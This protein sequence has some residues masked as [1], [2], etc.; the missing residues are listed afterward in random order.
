MADEKKKEKK[1]KSSNV[2]W[3][4]ALV[5]EII[6]MGGLAFLFFIY[7]KNSKFDQIQTV[8]IE[9]KDLE[10]N[11]G[12][13]EQ[14]KGYT[15][16]AFFGIDSRENDSMLEGNRSD[17]IIIA[18][19]NNDTKEVKL[20]SVYRDTLLFVAANGGVTTKTTHAYA[21]GGPT[22]ALS[23][24]NHNLDLEVTDFITVNFLAL[25]K[26]IDDLGGIVIDVR[27]EE[28]P[29]L[30]TCITEQI[31]ITGVYSDGVFNSGEQLLNGTQAT[32]WARIRSTDQGDITRTER[33]R[34]VLAKMVAKAKESDLAT[35]DKMLDDV[36]P[37]ISTSLTREELEELA[38]G[39]LDYSLGDTVGF[40][41]SYE[42][43]NSDTKGSIIV[44]ADLTAN[45]KA[46]HRFLFDTESYSPTSTVQKIS[47]DIS[48][49]TGVGEKEIDINVYTPKSE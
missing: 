2:K 33:Q 20:V 31:N 27:P 41:F 18:S 10:I 9:E 17:S 46:L 30:N 6:M 22:L 36:F 44:P 21:Y 40:P 45:V 11:E 15:T 47:S 43:Q 1:E 37:N 7:W 28:L 34:T 38:K 49:E 24:L 29:M 8:V 35:I 14:Q 5:V 16:I 39:M 13:N 4:I 19:I 26:A 23:T 25:S 48:L 32:A 12:A 3:L 42:M